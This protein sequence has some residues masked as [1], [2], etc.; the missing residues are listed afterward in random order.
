MRTIFA[1]SRGGLPLLLVLASSPIVL[2]SCVLIL[3][4][5]PQLNSPLQMECSTRSAMLMRCSVA[6]RHQ[7]RVDS[8]GASDSPESIWNPSCTKHPLESTSG[9]AIRGKPLRHRTLQLYPTLGPRTRPSEEWLEF[10]S[11]PWPGCSTLPERLEI[12]CSHPIAAPIWSN[13]CNRGTV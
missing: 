13:R 3:L 10:S 1:A 5:F 9:P 11:P 7:H 4:S 12:L 2:C 6:A 8:V